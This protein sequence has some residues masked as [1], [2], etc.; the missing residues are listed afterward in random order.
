MTDGQT[1]TWLT[2]H[3]HDRWTDTW[4]TRHQATTLADV[5]GRWILWMAV[6]QGLHNR[7][8]RQTEFLS[9][10]VMPVAARN[11][12]RKDILFLFAGPIRVYCSHLAR[13]RPGDGGGGNLG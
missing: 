4:L 9:N 10:Q 1:D 7:K 2:G 12:R 6:K 11:S 8:P 13:T 3:L 5:S